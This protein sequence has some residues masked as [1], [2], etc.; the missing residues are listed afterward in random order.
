MG[1]NSSKKK[2][3]DASKRFRTDLP[4]A[5]GPPS[6]VPHS[7]PT[8]FLQAGEED[9]VAGKTP[10]DKQMLE[11]ELLREVLH[12]TSRRFI[13]IGQAA[14]APA[15]HSFPK[16]FQSPSSR[17]DTSEPAQSRLPRADEGNSAEILVLTVPQV[18]LPPELPQFVSV[19]LA[20][21]TIADV[22]ELVVRLF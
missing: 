7:H 5:A 9:F 2:D 1:C 14:L 4:S 10:T 13:D 16:A 22:G 21:N 15:E 19:L 6:D 3:I 17:P 12:R 18:T 11:T 8:A 20:R